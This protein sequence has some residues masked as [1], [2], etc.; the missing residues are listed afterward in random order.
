MEV[1]MRRI[2]VL[3]FSALLYMPAPVAAQVV[4]PLDP[5]QVYLPV[6][7][8][9]ITPGLCFANGFCT[10]DSQGIPVSIFG[11]FAT[12]AALADATNRLNAQIAALS[13]TLNA[14]LRLNAAG[15]SGGVNFSFH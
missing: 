10:T 15:F 13:D 5:S 11:T 6:L 2:T 1:A 4:S 7:I 3:G 14:R 8:H 12:N 9:G